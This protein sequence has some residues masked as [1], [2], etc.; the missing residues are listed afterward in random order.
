MYGRYITYYAFSGHKQGFGIRC[1]EE[2]SKKSKSE[3]VGYLALG[4]T[5]GLEGQG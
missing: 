3:K 5:A 1:E 4:F 2:K